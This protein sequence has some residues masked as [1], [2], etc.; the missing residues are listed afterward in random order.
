MFAPAQPGHYMGRTRWGGAPSIILFRVQR[1]KETSRGLTKKTGELCL[2]C[3]LRK[4]R[5]HCPQ[6]DPG[7]NTQR[8]RAEHDQEVSVKRNIEDQ[9]H[10]AGDK[11]G[12]PEKCSQHESLLTVSGSPS[13][14]ESALLRLPPNPLHL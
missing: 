7:E 6:S 2:L 1:S 9:L 5:N 10:E 13:M 12:Y 3:R 8:R 11:Y 4:R 14:R